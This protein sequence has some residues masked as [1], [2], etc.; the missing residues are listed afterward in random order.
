MLVVQITM[1]ELRELSSIPSPSLFP[2]RSP[3][4][5]QSSRSIVLNI[6]AGCATWER[7]GLWKGEKRRLSLSLPTHQPNR[8]SLVPIDPRSRRRLRDYCGR[9]SPSP[10]ILAKRLFLGN[11]VPKCI[12]RDGLGPKELSKW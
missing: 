5:P 7:G 6:N 12:D 1:L 9:V 11:V 3:L 10:E 8:L 4:C 2:A